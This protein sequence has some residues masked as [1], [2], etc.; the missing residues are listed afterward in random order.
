MT[1]TKLLTATLL[2]MWIT[3]TKQCSPIAK[4]VPLIELHQLANKIEEYKKNE[5]HCTKNT[6]C[7]KRN[8]T[9]SQRRTLTSLTM[10]SFSLKSTVTRG[11][12]KLSP[13]K[14]FQKNKMLTIQNFPLSKTIKIMTIPSV[15]YWIFCPI[16]CLT[17]LLQVQARLMR[18]L[19]SSSKSLFIY[20]S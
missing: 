14:T 18:H 7:C 12:G 11:M 1:P 9:T 17:R 4:L 13:M 19:C 5:K 8:Q 6:I 10:H 3:T 16:L 20:S 15:L 2:I